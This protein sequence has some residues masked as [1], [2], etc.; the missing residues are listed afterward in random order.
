MKT[1]ISESK[2]KDLHQRE[3]LEDKIGDSIPGTVVDCRYTDCSVIIEFVVDVFPSQRFQQRLDASV[4]E[5][6]VSDFD[7]FVKSNSLRKYA[8]EY[9][10]EDAIQ[11]SDIE[12]FV[13]RKNN[14]IEFDLVENTITSPVVNNSKDHPTGL[15]AEVLSGIIIGCIP[16]SN[17][18]SIFAIYSE[19]KETDNMSYKR[20]VLWSSILATVCITHMMYLFILF[21]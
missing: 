15:S 10:T 9:A 3:K 12:V 21:I 1:S 8:T 2:I 11:D 19:M 6:E 7:V 18:L 13:N 16:V 14:R 17:Y 20:L 4:C 5:T